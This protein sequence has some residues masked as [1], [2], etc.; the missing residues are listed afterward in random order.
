[1]AVLLHLWKE[2]ARLTRDEVHIQRISYFCLTKHGIRMRVVSVSALC[3]KLLP[4]RS[5]LIRENP[6]LMIVCIR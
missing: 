5:N 2:T 6:L 1:M 3:S 4:L